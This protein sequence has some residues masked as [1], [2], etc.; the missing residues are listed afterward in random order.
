MFAFKILLDEI[1]RLDSKF[2][3]YLELSLFLS[4]ALFKKRIYDKDLFDC[5]VIYMEHL[6]AI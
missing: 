5:N 2:G 4:N 3:T 1:K 6:F